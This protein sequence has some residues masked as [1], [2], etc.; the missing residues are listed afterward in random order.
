[1]QPADRFPSAQAFEEALSDYLFARHIRWTRRRVSEVISAL[2]PADCK[3]LELPPP[4]PRAPLPVDVDLLAFQDNTTKPMRSPR[5]SPGEIPPPPPTDFS[6]VTPWSESIELHLKD[7]VIDDTVK[8]AL[9]AQESDADRFYVARRGRAEPTP[10]TVDQLIDLLSAAPADVTGVSLFAKPRVDLALLSRLLYWDA[11]VGLT[12]PDTS[13]TVAR[14]FDEIGITQLLYQISMRRVSGLVVIESEP[15]RRRRFIYLEQGIPQYI[16]S[17]DAR[18]GVLPVM[19]QNA[20]L[21]TQNLGDLL[22]RVLAEQISLD[23]ALMS[24][25]LR[26]EAEKV[27]HVFSATIRLRLFAA[28][29]WR[30]GQF[31][32]YPNAAPPVLLAVRIPPL[33]D[34]LV[35]AVLHAIPPEIIRQRLAPHEQ[36]P[37]RVE[38]HSLPHLAA[39]HLKGD[40]K[41]VA[42]LI[43]G[44]RTLA[45]IVKRR[46]S[47]SVDGEETAL[48]VFY[49]LAETRIARFG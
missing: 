36:K 14:S 11:L 16:A 35:D 15:E 42:D 33:V 37:V 1:K 6:E 12:E 43:D 21:G 48:A 2:F 10:A 46:A 8:V 41:A 44:K 3:P 17:D 32:I 19:R 40:E 22:E 5:A 9:L 4:S 30:H 23:W 34:V 28:F 39:L 7:L 38:K 45:A 29:A 13:P 26:E 47:R 49:V 25:S 18:D 31:R 24:S 20:L 27:E